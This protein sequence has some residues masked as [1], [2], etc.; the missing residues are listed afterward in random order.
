MPPVDSPP[1]AALAATLRGAYYRLPSGVQDAILVWRRTPL[2]LRAGIVFIHIPKAA[3][4]SFSSALYGGFLGHVPA[5]SIER[6][7][8]KAVRAL[9]SF[10]ITRNPW[11]R[12]VS[13]FRY[14]RRLHMVDWK[15]NPS[16]PRYVRQQVPN[17]DDFGDFVREWLQHQQPEKLNPIFQPQ[18]SYVCD[19][20]G[21]VLVDH[22][23]RVE[24]LAPTYDF[25][26][27]HLS[28]PLRI[29]QSN[30]SGERIDYRS[31]YTAELAEAVGRIYADDIRRF[32]YS[33]DG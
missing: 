32:G 11:D 9:P 25:L 26:E 13:A 12:A 6:W 19:R 27:A 30:E 10:A 15:A 14:G 29:G 24:D 31:F 2:W 4:T 1:G 5:S 16:V 3:G 33:F 28:A 23:G 8:S 20:S 7:A 22:L 21:K 18:W 17:F